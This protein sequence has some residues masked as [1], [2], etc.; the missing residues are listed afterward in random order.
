LVRCY[1]GERGAYYEPFLGGGAVFFRLRPE[2]SVLSDV[3]A[4]LIETY[5]AVRECPDLILSGLRRLAVNRETYYRLRKSKPRS[6][7]SKAVRFLYLNRTAFAGVYRLNRNGEFN[8]PFGGRSHAI[9][10]EQRLI[11]HAAD[12]LQSAHL[13][14]LDFEQSLR[15]AGPGDV[16]YCDPTYTVAHDRDG[17]VRYNEKNFSWAD[18]VRLASAAEAARLRGATVLVSN[19]HHPSVRALYPAASVRSVTRTSCVSAQRRARRRVTEYLFIL[20]SSAD[21]A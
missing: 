7:V 4:E 6:T 9:L 15:R 17:F 8:V 12:A 16:A 14:C 3:N 5:R 20:T 2:R 19:A 11:E 1:L 21:R 18:Q 13:R 10:L